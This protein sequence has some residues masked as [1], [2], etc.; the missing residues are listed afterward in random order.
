[1]LLFAEQNVYFI[2]YVLPTLGVSGQRDCFN[3]QIITRTKKTLEMQAVLVLIVLN[4]I[5]RITCIS[6]RLLY[7]AH[8]G[9]H[10]EGGSR[11]V[12]HPATDEAHLC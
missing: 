10:S 9:I 8:G 1:M 11:V 4:N 3:I 2:F 12:P 5:F 7:G 6:Y